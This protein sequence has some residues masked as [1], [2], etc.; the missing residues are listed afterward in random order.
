[1]NFVVDTGWYWVDTRAGLHF[2]HSAAEGTGMH[3]LQHK[4][5]QRAQ[6]ATSATSEWNAQRAP[7]GIGNAELIMFTIKCAQLECRKSAPIKCSA[8]RPG[9]TPH[10]Q[11]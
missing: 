7:V 10:A 11:W 1:M 6:I 3:A 9:S 2:V 5:P 4:S 8:A